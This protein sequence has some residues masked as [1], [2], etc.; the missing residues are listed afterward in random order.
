MYA[1]HTVTL[2]NVR[3]ELDKGT[4]EERDVAYITI[5]RGVLLDA[6]KGANV[7]A[8]GMVGA[9]AATLY[10]PFD[11]KAVDGVLRCIEKTYTGA[12]AFWNADDCSNLWTLSH[13]GNGGETFFIKGEFVSENISIAKAHDDCYVVTKVD[14]K[15]Y[16]SEDM[17]HWEVGGA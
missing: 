13:D 2:Y 10:I 15:D 9:D 7:R 17:R 8:T 1:P 6:A 16:G 4:F 14:M 5:L 11:V 3:Q 12:Q